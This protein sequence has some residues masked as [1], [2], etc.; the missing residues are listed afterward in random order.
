MY[1]YC[2]RNSIS[3]SNLCV[4]VAIIVGNLLIFH[5]SSDLRSR[6]FHL[7]P[8]LQQL[9]LGVIDDKRNLYRNFWV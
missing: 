4:N 6:H 3:L 8:N 5:L 2:S 1:C 7:H 9:Q